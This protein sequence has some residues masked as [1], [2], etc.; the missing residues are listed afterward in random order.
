MTSLPKFDFSKSSIKSTAELDTMAAEAGTSEAKFFR[1]GSYEVE[2]TKVDYQGAATDPNWGKFLMTLE[3]VGGR[4]INAQLIVPIKDSVYVTKAGKRTPIM[5]TK[6]K[7]A[8]E[9]LGLPVTI[10]T[11]QDVLTKNFSNPDK[12]LVGRR[13]TIEVQYKGN[14]LRYEGKEANGDK[15]YLIALASGATVNDA[16]GNPLIF[17]DWQSA[18]GYAEQNSIE[19]RKF[20]DVVGY[21]K[22][23]TATKLKAAN[24]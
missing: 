16:D 7:E 23:A 6:F 12:T 13:L 8:M 9:A 10:E 1:P 5:F 18:E 3:G 19:I 2:V 15:R 14:H 22:S 11:L 4:T 24:W 17:R 20:V 21:S